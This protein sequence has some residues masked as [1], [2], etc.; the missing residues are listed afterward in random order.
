MRRRNGTYFVRGT[1]TDAKIPPT[2]Y[3][4]ATKRYQPWPPNSG[5][6]VKTIDSQGFRT[7]AK[8]PYYISQVLRALC[9]V[10]LTVRTLK[11]SPLDL[12]STR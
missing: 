2:A 10:D 11:Y 5:Y 6:G 3:V 4:F 7:V 12:V 8:T 9:L 1:R